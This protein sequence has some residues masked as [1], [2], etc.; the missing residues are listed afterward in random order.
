MSLGVGASG[1][2]FFPITFQITKNWLYN[3]KLSPNIPP[4][5]K[6]ISDDIAV[7]QFP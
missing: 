6:F 7:L 5:L 3:V 4:S 1:L 2:V